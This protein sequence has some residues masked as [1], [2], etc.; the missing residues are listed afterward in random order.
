[1]AQSSITADS[2]S[3]WQQLFAVVQLQLP[4]QLRAVFDAFERVMLASDEQMQTVCDVRRNRRMFIDNYMNQ[5]RL[6]IEQPDAAWMQGTASGAAHARTFM[7]LAGADAAV[8][9]VYQQQAEAAGLLAAA[10]TFWTAHPVSAL[11]CPLAPHTLARLFFLLLNDLPAPLH[12][13]HGLAVTFLDMLPSLF[14][15]VQQSVLYFLKRKDPRISS[16]SAEPLPEWWEPLEAP[17][18]ASIAAQ[19]LVV[20]ERS[21]ERATSLALEMVRLALAGRHEDVAI[22]AATNRQ[23]AL[24]P[25]LALSLMGNALPVSARQM[26]SLLAG[27]L[28]LAACE[29]GFAD[30]AHPVRRVL[31][32]WLHWA[33]AWMDE[34]DIDSPVVEQLHEFSLALAQLLLQHP[35]NLLPGWIDLFD[36]LLMLRKRTRQDI[37]ASISSAR[38]SIQVMEARAE[39]DALLR[40]RAAN[41]LWPQ[42]VVDILHGIWSSLLLGI[43]WHEGKASDAWL[44]AIAVAD[45]LM[46]S[47]QPGLDRVARQSVMLRIPQLLQHLRAGF[48]QAGCERKDYRSV[49]VR[50]EKVHLALLQGAVE[51]PE[52][53]VFWPDAVASPQQEEAIAVGSWLQLDDGSRWQVMF[54]DALCSV[55]MDTQTA[56]LLCCATVALQRDFYAGGLVILP[57][58]VPLLAA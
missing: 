18:A 43:Y 54:S 34:P 21:R 19:A 55:L 39:V 15:H 53:A 22:L 58:P 28:L 41:A 51:L 37:S 47:V 9:N 52:P 17:P 16:L 24:L 3:P 49:L 31:E 35:G 12:I 6:R 25:W 40:E 57:A 23:T 33:P 26:L 11:S 4:E 42:I 14:T 5:L 2:E 13:R 20:P 1:M 45:D 7:Y 27:P 32:E 29:E 30:A 46:A 50:L 48:E 8:R 56:G 10:W 36:Y 38:L 44:H